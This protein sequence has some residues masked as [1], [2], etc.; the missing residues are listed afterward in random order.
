MTDVLHVT[1]PEIPIEA[2]DLTNHFEV[3][4]WP[5]WKKKVTTRAIRV[6]GPF[7]VKTREGTLT[8]PDGYLAMDAHGWP[9]PI[10]ANEFE[11]IYEPA[12]GPERSEG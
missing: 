8:C 2:A 11:A 5:E 12:S 9:Y 3:G 1:D 7:T 4:E 10:A 6:G